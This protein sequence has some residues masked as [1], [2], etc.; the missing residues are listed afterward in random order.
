MFVI[1]ISNSIL[2]RQEYKSKNFT[3]FT[4]KLSLWMNLNFISSD[5][6]RPQMTDLR[7]IMDMNI[8]IKTGIDGSN[9]LFVKQ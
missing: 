6:Y 4:N 3:A 1:V 9:I 5:Q 7:D 2:L 8:W